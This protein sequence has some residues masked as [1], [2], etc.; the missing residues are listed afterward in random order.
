MTLRSLVAQMDRCGRDD[1]HRTGRQGARVYATGIR[2]S[3]GHAF[4]PETGELWFTDNQVDG[5]GDDIP[6]GE[7]NRQTEAGQA[8]DIPGTVAAT[9]ERTSSRMRR[10]Q[11]D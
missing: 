10:P 8:S 9:C 7:I 4:H 11:K 1:P 3:V 5:M 6:P 2:N